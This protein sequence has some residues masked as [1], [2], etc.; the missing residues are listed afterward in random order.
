MIATSRSMEA[1]TKLSVFFI[2]PL[3]GLPSTDAP[4]ATVEDGAKKKMAS[5]QS[6]DI[7]ITN[8]SN[9]LQKELQLL[10]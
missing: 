10:L 7:R 4:S 5:S 9:N 1:R 3:L 8:A 2:F 6:S